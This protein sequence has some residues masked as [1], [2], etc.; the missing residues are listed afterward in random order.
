MHRFFKIELF[1]ELLK[2]LHASTFVD[3]IIMAGLPT[4]QRFLENI[5]QKGVES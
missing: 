1:Q 4:R 5:R 3:V 2:M